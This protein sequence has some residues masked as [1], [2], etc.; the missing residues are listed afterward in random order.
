[1]CPPTGLDFLSNLAGSEGQHRDTDLDSD[2]L[3]LESIIANTPVNEERSQTQE[4]DLFED[5]CSTIDFGEL[6]REPRDSVS[7]GSPATDVCLEEV[8]SST[9]AIKQEPPEDFKQLLIPEL[10]PQQHD[11]DSV[12]PDSKRKLVCKVCGDSASGYHYRVASCE[13]CK[14]F[15]KRT[16]QG[17]I[18]YCCQS[19]GNCRISI[20]GRKAC[21][22][23]RFQKCLRVGMIKEGVR[24]DRTRGGRQT[25]YR[26]FQAPTAQLTSDGLTATEAI[27]HALKSKNTEET[28]EKALCPYTGRILDVMDITHQ[29]Y[30]PNNVWNIIADLYNRQIEG[31]VIS[32][33]VLP[34]LKDFPVDDQMSLFRGGW[35]ELM[36]LSLIY[37]SRELVHGQKVLQ[38]CPNLHI[39]ELLAHLCGMENYFTKC[40]GI[41]T[42][43][44]QSGGMHHEEFLL[45]KALV[46][47]NVDIDMEDPSRLM[48][49]RD[50]VLEALNNTVVNLRGSL[51]GMRHVQKLLMLLPAIRECDLVMKGLLK[52]RKGDI[53]MRNTLFLDM[54]E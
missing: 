25:Y 4:E 27:L 41:I 52:E 37:Q 50:S 11:L 1:M 38:F 30:T 43:I 6:D 40:T 14:A 9:D 49:L 20:R 35:S 18:E 45:L 42:K 32:M 19:D 26:K 48:N 53:H 10:E 31:N 8:I 13:A 15:F 24:Q 5:I 2:Y 54:Q 21:Q 36:T 29:K 23:C 17:K 34:G 3:F 28:P 39:N 51:Q 47:A 44:A 12:A 7:S 16:V 46:L 33:K 22:A